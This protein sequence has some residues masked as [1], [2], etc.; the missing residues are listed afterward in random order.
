MKPSSIHRSAVAAALLAVAAQAHATTYRVI[1]RQ[2]AD[3]PV[4]ECSAIN[5]R[6]D[7]AG[8]SVTNPRARSTATTRSRW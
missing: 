7:T 5:A 6:G 1:P 8:T 4:V 3:G 2:A